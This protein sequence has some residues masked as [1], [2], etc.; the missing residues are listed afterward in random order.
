MPHDPEDWCKIRRKTDL[1][2]QTWQGFGELWR[3]HSKISKICTFI[4][5]YCAKYLIFDLKKYRGV[6]FHGTEKWCKIWRKTDMWFETN[7]VMSY[8]NEEWC[9]I[10]RGIDLLFQ[11]LL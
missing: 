4:G 5:S 6:V 1:L 2:F 9:K 7:W 8:G 11:N 10:W 3:D